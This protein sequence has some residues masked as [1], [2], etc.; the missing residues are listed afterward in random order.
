MSEYE[1]VR[2]PCVRFAV[3]S[4]Q[5]QETRRLTGCIPLTYLQQEWDLT[6]KGDGF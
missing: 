5:R 2:D 1:R 3:E 4:L 6:M